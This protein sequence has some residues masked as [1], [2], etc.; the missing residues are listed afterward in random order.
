MRI[1]QYALLCLIVFT[2]LI[3]GCLKQEEPTAK[4]CT[5]DANCASGYSC[6][7]ELP[8]GPSAGIRGSKEN[9]GACYDNGILSQIV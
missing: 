4:T 7:A 8:I 1:N 2:L 5:N 9:P 6:W 3:S